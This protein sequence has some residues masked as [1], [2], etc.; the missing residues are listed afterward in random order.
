MHRP[1]T[2]RTVDAFEGRSLRM[3]LLFFFIT[4]HPTSSRY[5]PGLLRHNTPPPTHIQRSAVLPGSYP[6]RWIP[7]LFFDRCGVDRMR[8]R[9]QSKQDSMS[10]TRRIFHSHSVVG[11]A[12]LI[13]RRLLFFLV[14]FG[15]YCSSCPIVW[16]KSLTDLR[17]VSSVVCSVVSQ[18]APYHSSTW[19]LIVGMAG[20]I[21]AFWFIADS[22]AL[23]FLVRHSSFTLTHY[24]PYF[25]ISF[26]TGPAE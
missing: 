18:L 3:C 10:R 25:L 22:Q 2:G 1:W 14:N 16:C 7:W 21:V 17:F 15:Q 20:L 23:R 8:V 19:L 12:K 13:V 6:A 4:A 11:Q 5:T 9:H 24:A 26:S